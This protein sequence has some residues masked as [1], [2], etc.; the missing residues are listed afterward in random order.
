MV[1]GE[2]KSRVY[3]VP[4]MRGGL[5]EV[6]ALIVGMHCPATIKMGN[7]RAYR[8]SSGR[9]IPACAGNT[10]AAARKLRRP[11]VHPRVCGEHEALKDFSAAETGSS[12]RVRG[13]PGRVW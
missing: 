10:V 4:V 2:R 5:D 8:T 1:R 12:P 6:L 9:F 7:R 3:N 13:T 11:P